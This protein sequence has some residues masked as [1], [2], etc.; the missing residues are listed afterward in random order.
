[1][2]LNRERTQKVRGFFSI[3]KSKLLRKFI[4]EIFFVARK[5]IAR[6]GGSLHREGVI[7][8]LRL[9][10]FRCIAGL[11]IEIPEQGLVFVGKNA[12]GKTSLLE[13]LCVLVRLHSP[14]TRRPNQM[15][16]FEASQFGVAGCAWGLERRVDYCKGAY[17]LKVDGEERDSQGAYLAD[18]G[19]VV[20]MGN[21]DRELVTG[22]AEGR[23]RYLDFIA[24]QIVPGY[25]RAL[26]RYRK[27]LQERN[28]LLRDGRGSGREM[29]S[30][31]QL[32]VEYG[33]EVTVGREAMV[34]N[35]DEPVRWAQGVV[36][37]SEEAV[38][39]TYKAAAGDDFESSLAM[40]REKE[41]RQGMTLVG[42]HRDEVKLTLGGLKASDFASEGQQRTLALALKLGQGELLREQGGRTPVYLLDDIFGE[43]DKGRRER[44]LASLPKGAQV[45]VTTTNASWLGE[46]MDLEVR[47]V[48]GG[49]VCEEG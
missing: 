19:L 21:E 7:A 28:A 16:K 44:F 38:G 46:G 9:A 12:Q 1:M 2:S 15:V 6:E 36:G 42:P 14:R 37:G 34:A 23:R 11:S 3:Y 25:R 31:T 5:A 43:L 40:V 18:G 41:Q 4:R 45:I 26:S 29:D 35:L 33:R 24:S 22:A 48:S 8:S 13:A 27:V 32:L 30:F 10:D 47:E 17:A 49:R 39:L 20:W